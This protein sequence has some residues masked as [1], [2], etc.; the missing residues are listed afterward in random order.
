MIAVELS[1]KSLTIDHLFIFSFGRRAEVLSMPVMAARS[2][3]SPTTSRPKYIMLVN[4]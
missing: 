2:A 4:G 3:K 1:M